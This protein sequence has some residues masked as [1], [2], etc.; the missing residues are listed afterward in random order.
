MRKMFALFLAV[1]LACVG[2][3]IA[4][5][6]AAPAQNAVG[7]LNAAKLK[8]QTT[9][10]LE[11]DAQVAALLSEF[12]KTA[13]D[14]YSLVKACYDYLIE[15]MSYPD[16]T[17][18]TFIDPHQDTNETF[19]YLVILRARNAL[20][21]GIGVCDDYA[22]TFVVMAR[23]IGLEA[24]NPGGQTRMAGG[25]YTGHAWAEIC[26]D[27]VFYIFDAQLE[28]N[29]TRNGNVQYIYFCKTKAEMTGRYIWD[30][31][32]NDMLVAAYRAAVPKDVPELMPAVRILYNGQD[33]AFA[34]PPVRVGQSLLVPMRAIFEALGATI[35]WDG[36]TGHITAYYNGGTIDLWVNNP[37]ALLNAEP[38]EMAAPPKIVSD[39]T[40]VPV[41][42]I[43]E[44]LQKDV[45][46][47]G[48]AQTVLIS[49]R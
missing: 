34:M 40:L 29:V 19:P 41:R 33:I 10:N 35:S 8:P 48:A 3:P 37:V 45:V 5:T 43:S 9:G 46:W 15:F 18:V 44:S 23:A 28:D 17:P 30:A 4:V 39:H 42:F 25:G 11:L 1:M 14:T 12:R 6:A 16:F 2:A 27:G 47:D 22:A 31:E 32:Y 36:P 20:A 7:I 49:D 13:T 21:T 38:F 26:I 24:F